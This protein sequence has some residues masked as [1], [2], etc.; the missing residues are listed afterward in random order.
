MISEPELV[1]EFGP[2]HTAEAVGG[3]DR[4]PTTGRGRGHHV[5]WAAAGALTA[6]A[7]WAV[8]VF[9]YGSDADPKPD[10]HGYRLDGHSCSALRM[11]ALVASVGER[12]DAPSLA[13][14]SIEH[15]A[16]DS[17]TCAMTV[18]APKGSEDGYG[19]RPGFHVGM[20]A[21][22]H[23]ETDPLPEFEARKT[24]TPWG[25]GAQHIEP[26]PGLGDRAYLLV[27]DEGS[28]ELR[29]VEGG[30][31]IRL[32]LSASMDYPGADEG[33]EPPQAE[34]EAPATEPYHADLISD[35]RDVMEQLKR[36]A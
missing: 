17:I 15:P 19:W 34:P 16:L 7:I 35:M 13:P 6:S 24:E 20:R 8:A 4:K 10:T 14:G 26:V 36:T 2:E 12:A 18:T 32:T 1:G 11:K 29:V 9:A 33:K 5:L 3:F 31:V 28:S 22:L 30:A 27:L 21:E 25:E 23:K